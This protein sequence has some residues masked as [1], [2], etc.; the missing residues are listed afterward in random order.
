VR[1][2]AFWSA[3]LALALTGVAAEWNVHIE[4]RMIA[5][6]MAKAL[7]LVPK[8]QRAATFAAAEAQVQALL[9]KGEAEVLGWTV[10][11]TQNGQKAGA[12]SFEEV[13]YAVDFNPPTIPGGVRTGWRPPRDLKYIFRAR[14]IP[15]IAFDTRD[16]GAAIEVEPVV[17]KSGQLIE[18]TMFARQ[19]KL[20]AMQPAPGT[21]HVDPGAYP[22]LQPRFSDL[23][24]TASL[25]IP[26]GASVLLSTFVQEQPKPRVVLFLLRAVAK[27]P[28]PASP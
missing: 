12:G 6:P 28:P 10:V 26:N 21:R 9:A 1:F 8:L 17:E 5:V 4:L 22:S 27:P 15:P 25:T 23:V 2:H 3:W 7:P 19:V 24:T 18:L 11:E 13:R 14:Q 16:C 20:E